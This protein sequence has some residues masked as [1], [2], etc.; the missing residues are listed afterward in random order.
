MGRNDYQYHNQYLMKG[1]I[2]WNM[3]RS[4]ISSQQTP[5][6]AIVYLHISLALF[7]QK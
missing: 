1:H 3:D 5:T 6:T 2:D 7:S 4:G